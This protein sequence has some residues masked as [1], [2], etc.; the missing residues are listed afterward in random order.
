MKKFLLLFCLPV[1]GFSQNETS[2][3]ATIK[4]IYT[5]A[6]TEN[7]GYQWLKELTEIGGRLAGS[8]EADEA[9]MR[10]KEI[11]DSLGFK[12]IL[13]PV[14]VPKWTRGA[15]EQAHYFYGDLSFAVNACALG[16]SVPTEGDGLSAKVIEVKSFQELADR[17][18]EVKDKIVFFNIPMDAAYINTFFAYRDAVKQRWAGA[19]E[20]SKFGAAGV[21]TRSLS[22][23]INEFPH[24]GSMTYEGAPRKIPAISISTA[25]SE[26]LSAALQQRPDLQFYMKLN[27]EWHDS[28]MSHNLIAEIKGGEKPDEVILVGGHIDSWDLGTGAHDDG[29][30][31]IHSLESAWLLKKLGILPKR[32]LRVVF[33]MNEEFGLD[34][35]EVYADSSKKQNINHVIAIESDAGGFTPRGIS[36]V[37]PDAIIQKI[38]TFRDDLEPYGIH[39]FSQQGA[40]ADIGKLAS[41]SIVLIGMRPDNHRYFEVHHSA[42]DVLENVNPRELELGSATMAALVW[43]LDKYDVVAE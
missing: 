1:F 29:A 28:V 11:C 5:T 2:D 7:Q 38:K 43:L 41:D 17:A 32:T 18:S 27:C 39:V 42:Q 22:A 34:G 30:G 12:T 40:G 10:M 24:T 37:A 26:K 20:A 15:E 36:M 14:K 25:D 31:C 8:P 19:L 23:T 4:K 21:V 13:Q 33:F 9:V 6:L 16:G 3:A 35:A